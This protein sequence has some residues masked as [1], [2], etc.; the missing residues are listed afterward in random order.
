MTWS[1]FAAKS[2]DHVLQNKGAHTPGADGKNKN[3]YSSAQTRLNWQREIIRSL[4]SGTFRPL[5]ARRV[6][7]PKPNKPGQKRPL[8]IPPLTDRVVQDMLRRVL[9]PIFESR[10]HP[11]SY[12]FR[13][14]RS[15]HHAVQRV[16]RLI[17]DGYT[18]VVEGDIKGFFDHVDHDI[19]LRLVRK[20]VGDPRILRLIRAFLKAGVLE[21]GCFAVTDEGTPQGGLISPLLGNVYL[22]E[23]DWFVARKYE[24]IPTAYARKK[25]PYGCFICRY[26]DDFVILVR[27]TREDAEAL[28][29]E[30]A[31]FLRSQLRLELSLEK[32]L[33]THVD[34]G[35]DFLGFHIRR[36]ERNGK[37]AILAQ[38]SQKAQVRFRD[39]IRELTRDVARHGGNLWILDLNRYL[40]G[41][42]EY[43][44]RGNSKRIFSKLDHI[45]WWIIALQMR[46]R[47]RRS[48]MKGGFG[49]FMRQQLIPYRYDIQHPHYRRYSARNFGHWVD[50]SR[51]AAL[52]VDCLSYYPI[53]Y[54][55][56]FTQVHPYTPDGRVKVES[57]RKA[58]RLVTDAWR[59]APPEKVNGPKVYGLLQGWLADRGNRCSRC[60]KDLDRTDLRKLL[61][62]LVGRLRNA[63]KLKVS[64]QCRTCFALCKD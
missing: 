7:I 50:S 39:R 27:G 61:Y 36:Y 64:L 23:L 44:R 12:G 25:Q 15:A 1:V 14:C 4:R 56:C 47:W 22:N 19:L 63:Y 46:G 11:H 33:V 40:V 43:F 24:T 35:F 34:E 2:I 20:E 9:E 26:A 62:R 49:N 41:W 17:Q 58:G 54:A 37:K 16:R 13:P 60:G 8:G 6:Y 42:A 38:P 45:L 57:I 10:F 53:H 59:V 30:V 3:D 28:K 51:T 5:P 55:P 31:D 52:I 18:W 29:A 32:T 48:R 21:D